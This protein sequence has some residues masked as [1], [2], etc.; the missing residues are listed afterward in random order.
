[1]PRKISQCIARKFTNAFV[2]NR[3][4]INL[5]RLAQ[6]KRHKTIDTRR[7]AREAEG[8]PLLREY[9]VK[10]LIEG[11]NP[12]LS[13]SQETALR[14]RLLLCRAAMLMHGELDEQL[15]AA[16]RLCRAAS[17]GKVRGPCGRIAQR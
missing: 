14:G 2:A 5:S 17:L 1:M 3:K 13:A 11:S 8:A 16:C 12:S 10:S 15:A 4:D 9:R 7:D 6:A